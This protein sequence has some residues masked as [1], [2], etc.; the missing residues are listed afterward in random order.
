MTIVGAWVRATKRNV[1]EVVVCS[2]SR[3]SGGGL[4]D[5]SPKIF[6]LPRSDAVLAFSGNTQLAYPILLQMSHAISCHGPMRD[7]I[8]DIVPLT[9]YLKRILNEL[10]HGLR[11]VVYDD[12]K[13]PD[14]NFLLCGYSW[15]KKE[16]IIE[17]FYFNKSNKCFETQPSGKGVGNFGKFRFIG[18][19]RGEATTRL[20]QLLRQRYGDESVSKESTLM[21]KYN[22]EPFEVI[23]DMLRRSTRV[24]SIGGAPQIV[25]VGQHMISKPLGVFWPS[26]NDRKVYVNGRPIFDFENIDNWII[27]PD[28]LEKY[29]KQLKAW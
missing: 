2:D 4:M 20:T 8:I 11:E 23:R 13:E 12:L 22:M 26:M 10:F 29:H 3:L 14:T 7:G 19:V 16:F 9:T 17:R 6:Q 27:D 25:A 15:F 5:C 21:Q 28:T 18:D 1:E 24:D